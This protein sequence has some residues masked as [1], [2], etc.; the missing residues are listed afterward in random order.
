MSLPKE[1]D[2]RR[3]RAAAGKEDDQRGDLGPGA[4]GKLSQAKGR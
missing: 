1:R 4:G 2:Y 3:G